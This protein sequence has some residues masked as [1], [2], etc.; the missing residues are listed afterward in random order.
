[1]RRRLWLVGLLVLGLLT[2][3]YGFRTDKVKN[4]QERTGRASPLTRALWLLSGID[5]AP[6]H[7]RVVDEISLKPV[8]GAGCILPETNQ[9]V[10]TDE[11]GLTPIIRAPVLRN[12]RRDDLVGELAGELTMICYKNGYRDSIVTGI[13]MYDDTETQ[14]ELFM[15][16]IGPKDKRIEPTFHHI[17]PHRLWQVQLAD[18]F[19]LFDEGQGR[20]SPELTRPGNMVVPQSKIGV[21]VQTPIRPGPGAPAENQELQAPTPRV[22]PQS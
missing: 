22:S 20:E 8:P 21:G 3:T 14:F 10:E 6:L 13:R 7:V 4:P 18:R 5:T 15:T 16:P 12:P 9:R 19:R 1:M 17:A 11:K 2:G